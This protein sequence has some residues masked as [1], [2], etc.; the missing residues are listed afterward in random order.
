[1]KLRFNINIESGA[2]KS[3][4]FRDVDYTKYGA[5]IV[6]R[7]DIWNNSDILLKVRKPNEYEEFNEIDA[8]EKLHMLVSYFYPA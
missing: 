6:S 7:D 5:T 3:A 4:G 1:M 8:M 2:G